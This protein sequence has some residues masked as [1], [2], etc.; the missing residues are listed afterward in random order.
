MEEGRD[1]RTGIIYFDR[2]SHFC[3]RYRRET[4]D[5]AGADYDDFF[6]YGGRGHGIEKMESMPSSASHISAGP[7]YASPGWEMPVMWWLNLA[8]DSLIM[9]SHRF[10]IPTNQD[11]GASRVNGRSSSSLPVCF[12]PI[13]NAR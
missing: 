2:P 5:R 3:K 11:V 4:T 8:S 6:C 9:L 10:L 7:Y 13:S 1:T 12:R